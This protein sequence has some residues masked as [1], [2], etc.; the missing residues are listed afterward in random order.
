MSLE[1]AGISLELDDL[2]DHTTLGGTLLCIL[3][4]ANLLAN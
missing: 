1:A 4:K 3:R 2:A